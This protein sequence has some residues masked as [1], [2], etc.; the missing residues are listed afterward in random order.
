LARALLTDW[1]HQGFQLPDMADPVDN[2]ILDRSI[3]SQEAIRFSQDIIGM[4]TS[5]LDILRNGYYPPFISEVPVYTESNNKSAVEHSEF[6]R[7]KIAEWES[8]GYVER[9]DKPAHCVNP[10]SVAVKYDAAADSLKLRPVL[11]LSRHVNL[12]VPDKSVQLD[13]LSR[14]EHLLQQGDYMTAFDLRNQFFHVQLAPAARKFFGFAIPDSD[15]RLLYY[16]FTVMVYGL[17]SAVHVVTKLILPLKAFIHKLG[18]RFTIYID[19]G[20]CLGVEVE[21]T[22]WKQFLVLTIFQLAGWSVQWAKTVLRP[23]QILQHQGFIIDTIAMRYFTPVEKLN[24]I[25]ILLDQLFDFCRAGTLIPAKFIALV[26]GKIISLVR[27]HGAIVR[28]L[29]RATQHVLGV[30]VTERGWLCA[31]ALTED[32]I[33]E[34]QMLKDILYSFNGQFI[35]AA[36]GA[37]AIEAQRIQKYCDVIRNSNCDLPDLFVSDASDTAAF[38]YHANGTFS[39][40]TEF[41]FDAEQ[42]LL[43]SGLRELLAVKFALESDPQYFAQF[44]NQTIF[45][46][47]DSQ[48]CVSF[49]QR[50]SRRP[51]IQAVVR[52]IKRAEKHLDIVIVPVWTPREQERARVAD[53]GSKFSL[54]SDEWSVDRSV[55]HSVFAAAG[56]FPTV[57]CFATVFNTV[58]FKFFSRDFSPDAV[59][60]NFFVQSL[61]AEELYFCCPPVNLIVPCF[62]KLCGA[63]AVRALLLVPEWPSAGFWPVLFP[64]GRLHPVFT[65]VWRFKPSFFFA[66]QATSN[67]FVRNPSFSMLAL[68]M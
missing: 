64:D 8:A 13:D 12:Y 25:S 54:D 29:S 9:L 55:L 30:A 40:M 37:G 49:L 39:Y 16:Q 38:V 1:Y 11:D 15:G 47:T 6:L 33:A 19:D 66:N 35:C 10:L 57:D 45:W 27:S 5:Q 42:R 60:V 56:F 59:A 68:V 18:I 58:C 17:K 2:S 28:V 50:G 21:D 24:V 7:G 41:V 20:H 23:T 34:L 32:C 3:H 26:L 31:V 14:S 52:D 46:Q 36:E 65:H 67:V 44:R 51:H 43:G 63:G 22:A 53:I 48:N 61:V 62:R 4:P